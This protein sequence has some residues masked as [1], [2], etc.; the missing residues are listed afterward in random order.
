MFDEQGKISSD[1]GTGMMNLFQS[2]ISKD[3]VSFSQFQ[4]CNQTA[5]SAILGV[6]P[7]FQEKGGY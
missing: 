3:P 1:H 5:L 2:Y 4:I 7:L 6:I